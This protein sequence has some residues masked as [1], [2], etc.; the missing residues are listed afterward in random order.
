MGKASL[1]GLGLKQPP[2]VSSRT[3]R[4]GHA[5]GPPPPGQASYP[6]GPAPLAQAQ[7]RRAS[8]EEENGIN[9]SGG[10]GAR[11]DE[12]AEGKSLKTNR[13]LPPAVPLPHSFRSPPPQGRFS[14]QPRPRA[15]RG[16]PR[17]PFKD[18]GEGEGESLLAARPRGPRSRSW[19]SRG[20]RPR[21][22]DSMARGW[23]FREWMEVL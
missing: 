8:Q 12:R 15:H 5:C 18:S 20:R 10:P 7:R 19:A 22:A 6:Q 11:A 21:A 14:P 9:K 16:V 4:G 2:P 13:R 23:R 17:G 3:P 1:R